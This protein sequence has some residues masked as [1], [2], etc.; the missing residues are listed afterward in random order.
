MSMK[1][2]GPS[3][4]IHG[5]GL[6][7]CFP[8]HED[9]IAQSESFNGR[10]FARYW[11]HNGLMQYGDETR[12]IGA[13]EN[14]LG[15]QEQA[16]MSKS[17]GNV[18]TI[19]ELLD[20][21]SPETVR[22]FLLATH[23][24][25]PIYFTD[26]RIEEVGRGLGRL[27]GLCERIER[28]LGEPFCALAAPTQRADLAAEP[29]APFLAAAVDLRS[30]FLDFMDDDFNTGG[31]VGVLFDL[32]NLMNR[33]ADEQRLEESISATSD[34]EAFRRAAIILR[35]LSGILGVLANRPSQLNLQDALAPKLLDL[36]MDVR[37]Q[38]RQ[39]KQFAI[40]DEIRNVLNKIGVA[41]EDRA[42]GTYWKIRD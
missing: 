26:E 12:K 11:M 14:D 19:T 42:D 1:L 16:K 30:K 23:Y 17:K 41:I 10:P 40:A 9:E 29:D 25:R 31:A 38:L 28:V 21:H 24:R 15:S 3:F 20:R 5:G 2:L 37:R 6:D 27:Y 4:D 13:R 22:F 36:L 34:R 32:A 39:S 8:H 33:F 7:L 18:I 35:E